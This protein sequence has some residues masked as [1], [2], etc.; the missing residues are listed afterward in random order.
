VRQTLDDAGGVLGNVQYDPWGVPTAG[1]PQP[2]GF[3]GEV[4]SA[5]QVYL[6]ARWYAPGQGTFT[7]R[8]P[9]AGF[10]EMPYSLHAYQ[11]GYSNPVFNTDP[12][13]KQC[14][15]AGC[16]HP[17]LQMEEVN[18]D[19]VW[20]CF[21]RPTIWAA[22]FDLA[23]PCG[24]PEESCNSVILRLSDV[25]YVE[26]LYIE[27]GTGLVKGG[28]VRERVWN[29]HTFEY[30]EFDSSWRGLTS[31]QYGVALG[32]YI[33]EIQGWGNY[34]SEQ[35]S[36]DNYA[37][38]F[39]FIGVSVGAYF[40]NGSAARFEND[41]GSMKGFLLGADIGYSQSVIP[42]VPAA[43]DWG[44][45]KT[46]TPRS[47][48]KQTWRSGY[49]G[50]PTFLDGIRFA[51]EFSGQYGPYSMSSLLTKTSGI[52]AAVSNGGEWRKLQQ[53]LARQQ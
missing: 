12:T 47:G 34:R 16:P 35:F 8:D 15:G 17:I 2:F 33:G 41:T 48:T 36:V 27:G 37:G 1:T 46:N 3:T 50:W 21:R 45:G 29:L 13:G 28:F 43:V 25:G 39:T 5:G 11:Y 6:R 18:I 32:R 44:T 30:A 20:V 38:D 40:V 22:S 26:A 14:E 31:D 4:H 52:L 53:A 10:A 7:S 42:G 23:N 9:F 19:G 49:G 24:P 51:N